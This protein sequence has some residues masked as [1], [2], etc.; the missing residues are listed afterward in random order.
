M[1]RILILCFACCLFLINCNSSNNSNQNETN[2]LKKDTISVKRVNVS[3]LITDVDTNYVPKNWFHA[4]SNVIYYYDSLPFSG[5]LFSNYENGQIKEEF[6]LKNGQINGKF[7]E[8]YENGQ[9]KQ[10]GEWYSEN[11]Q[12]NGNKYYSSG[13]IKEKL[14]IENYEIISQLCLDKQG[15]EIE[16]D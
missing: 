8:F 13:Q 16:C 10:D 2:N 5:I 14:K 15:N 6:N 4:A 12:L 1:K 7:K 3:N 11:G 9:L